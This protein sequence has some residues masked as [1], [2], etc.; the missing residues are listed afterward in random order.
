M[1]EKYEPTILQQIARKQIENGVSEDQ[2]R[3]SR[4]NCEGLRIDATRA[5]IIYDK[6]LAEGGNPTEGA[7]R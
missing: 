5:V 7:A 3:I 1:T 6:H 4:E 2:L